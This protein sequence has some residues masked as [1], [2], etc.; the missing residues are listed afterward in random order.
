[1]I[2]GCG[3]EIK[4]EL[5][6]VFEVEY[7]SDFERSILKFVDPRDFYTN[8]YI[9]SDKLKYSLFHSKLNFEAFRPIKG[10]VKCITY[11][12]ISDWHSKTFELF[13]LR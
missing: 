5:H 8:F 1:M 12:E 7:S 2:V 9:I 13:Y 10:R 4:P 6:S 3:F 11:D